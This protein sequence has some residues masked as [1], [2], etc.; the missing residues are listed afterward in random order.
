MDEIKNKIVFALF[1]D[2][3]FVAWTYGLFTQLVDYPKVYSE[4]ERQID[5]VV[6][7]FNSK[8]K[9]RFE[10]SDLLSK[11][12]NAPGLS[13]IDNSQNKERD[14]LCNFKEFELRMY[15]LP[16]SENLSEIDLEKPVKSFGYVAK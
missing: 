6:S 5:V 4:S 1:G 14:I 3:N 12:P 2:N 10:N 8:I 16:E 11:M 9:R 7:N 15:Y 13:V